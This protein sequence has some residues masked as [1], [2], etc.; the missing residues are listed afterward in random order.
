MNFKEKLTQMAKTYVKSVLYGKGLA[1]FW[2]IKFYPHVSPTARLGIND[3][4]VN[5]ENLFMYGNSTLKR[6]SVIMNRRAKFILH[7]NSGSAEELMVITGNHM[8]IVGKSV[9]QVTDKVKDSEDVRR[10]FDRDVIVDEDVWIGARVTI[11]QGVHVGRGSELGTGAVIRCNI[12]PYSIVIGNPAKIVGFRFTPEEI[13]E[14]EKILYKEE[15]RLPLSFL[16]KNY[17]KYYLSKI[18]EIRAYLSLSC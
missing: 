18:K 12:P 7:N 1:R 10:E 8:S 15:E 16:E 6:D 4:I 13:I 14:H 17:E 9:K 2:R 11:L 5:D 3:V